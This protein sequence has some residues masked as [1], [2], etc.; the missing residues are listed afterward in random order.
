MAP[1]PLP[2]VVVKLWH[3]DSNAGDR[4]AYFF[5]TFG[6]TAAARIPH[7]YYAAIDPE[8]DRGVLILADLAPYAQ[9]DDLLSLSLEKSIPQPTGKLFLQLIWHHLWN[10][11]ASFWM[12]T[13]CG[14]N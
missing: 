5:N 10:G 14:N 1:A 8:T 7:C 9:G 11:L 4:E 3:T 6:K 13:N 12:K 2:S